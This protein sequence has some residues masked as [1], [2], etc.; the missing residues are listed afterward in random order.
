MNMNILQ[1][2]VDKLKSLLQSHPDM[3]DAEVAEKLDA[4]ASVAGEKLD[5]RNSI[6]DL[7]KLLDLDSSLEAR[8]DLADELG[9]IGDPDS[10]DEMNVW[11]HREVIKRVGHRGI[12]I[13]V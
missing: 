6:V 1:S 7:M 11:L 9:Y 10:S 2:I 13:P 12:K 5:W 8:E 3:T 4:R